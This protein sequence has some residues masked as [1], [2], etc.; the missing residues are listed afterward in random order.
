MGPNEVE[1]VFV[2]TVQQLN[3]TD[4]CLIPCLCRASLK[5]HGVRL[6]EEKVKPSFRKIYDYYFHVSA[7]AVM[8]MIV[9]FIL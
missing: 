4:H 2:W 1:F 5:E 8:M 7:E 9:I 3:Y 6:I